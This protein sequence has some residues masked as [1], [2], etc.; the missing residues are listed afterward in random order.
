MVIDDKPL[1]W[2]DKRYHSLNYYL[3]QQFGEKIGKITLDGGFTCPN[4]DGTLAWGGCL[5]CSPS[6]SGD[7]IAARGKPIDEQFAQG[8]E[9][10]RKKWD[11]DKYI[12]YLQSYTNTYAPVDKL[13]QLYE[14]ALAL[15]GVAGLSIATRPDCLPEEVLDLLGEINQHHYLTVELGLQTI[16]ERSAD[17][18]NLQYNYQHFLKALDDLQSRKINVCTHIILGLPGED[19]DDMMATA[20]ALAGLPIQ[21]IKIQLLHLMRGTPLAKIYENQ[22]FPFLSKQEYVDLV[23]NILEILPPQMVIHRLTGDSPRKTLIGPAWS[24]DKRSVL[25]AID[26]QLLVENSWQGRLYRKN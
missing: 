5:F 12:A 6:G 11:V 20:T 22:S 4:R 26:R 7:F 24:M 9:V 25:N 21:G 10:I 23:V 17:Y 15:P 2:D 3:R 16:H 13:R 8:R 18:F 1:K 14:T 19:R